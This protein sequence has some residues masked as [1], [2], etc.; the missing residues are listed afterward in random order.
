MMKIRKYGFIFAILLL[1]AGCTPQPNA[2]IAVS[3]T[4][5]E[6]SAGSV[7]STSA[8]AE[9]SDPVVKYILQLMYLGKDDSAFE[10]QNP[11]AQTAAWQSDAGFYALAQLLDEYMEQA[12]RA[13]P[14][15]FLNNIK[16][17]AVYSLADTTC[18][19]IAY[20][21]PYNGSMDYVLGLRDGIRIHTLDDFS[22]MANLVHLELT[23]NT[24]IA[25]FSALDRLEQLESLSIR[26]SKYVYHETL[27]GLTHLKKLSLSSEWPIT[28]LEPFGRLT[29]LTS[30]SLSNINVP[31]LDALT[32][33]CNLEEFSL[34]R[35]WI[36]NL[37]GMAS[38][39]N[40]RQ[41]RLTD[42]VINNLSPLTALSAL[43]HLETLDLCRNQIEELFP[44]SGLSQLK[45]LRLCDNRI[46]DITSLGSLTGLQSLDL[47]Y[48]LIADVTPLTA[49]KSLTEL[50]V[51][52]NKIVS[53]ALLDELPMLET[54]FSTNN[55]ATAPQ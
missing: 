4:L 31:N 27:T 40:L 16:S 6:Q 51:S 25:D 50:N 21:Q 3:G 9:W 37:E 46:A 19:E 12:Q 10:Q 45:E 54:L 43:E 42:G 32:S 20:H 15:S 52:S 53:L 26:T 36:P 41:L 11:D 33:L 23:Y 17:V 22:R 55:P 44:V 14:Q 48:N 35:S 47:E 38:F 30:L 29:R 28:D 13:I 34:S 7:T 8:E 2:S 5:T 24:D 39:T 1:V 49:L 18:A